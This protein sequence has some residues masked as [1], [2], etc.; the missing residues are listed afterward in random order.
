MKCRKAGGNACEL[1]ISKNG[2]TKNVSTMTVWKQYAVGKQS[3]EKP[4]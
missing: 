2:E 3:L 4:R 1:D